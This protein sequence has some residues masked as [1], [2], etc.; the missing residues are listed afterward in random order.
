MKASDVIAGA[1]KLLVDPT[2]VRWPDADLLG[3]VGEAQ[4]QVIAV[5]PDSNSKRADLTLVA[6][7]EQ[8][9][10]ADGTRLLSVLQNVGGRVITLISRNELNSIDV[11]WPMASPR[12][13]Q[14]HY[15]F[16]AD[17]PKVFEVWPPAIAGSKARIA[18]A[19][20]PAE[21]A[22]TTD[23]LTLDDIYL[24]SL[25]DWVCYRAYETDSD[26]P[27]DVSRAANHLAAFMQ[28]LTGKSQSDVAY[29]PKRK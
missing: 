18:Y 9:I 20:V 27:S 7:V 15:M 3:W 23:D 24:P 8:S 21:V 28:A 22:A 1:R 13:A 6:G 29:E 11:N 14:R 2:G 10:P 5:R 17:T 16:D 25:T 4:L 12:T 26:D 19:A